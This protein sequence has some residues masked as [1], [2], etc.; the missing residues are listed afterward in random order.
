M[1]IL[2][3]NYSNLLNRMEIESA[4][5]LRSFKI[6]LGL[7]TSFMLAYVAESN[8]QRTTL[9]WKDNIIFRSTTLLNAHILD[10]YLRAQC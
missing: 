6:I 1:F 9:G 10:K 5:F 4:F 3:I 7:M 8:L 2:H